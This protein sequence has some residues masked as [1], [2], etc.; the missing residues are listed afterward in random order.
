[1]IRRHFIKT[2]LA[3]GV[4]TGVHPS[5]SSGATSA[6]KKPNAK[7]RAGVIGLGWM[8]LLYDLA[9]RIPDRFN[10][11][12][13]NRPTP[14]LDI[15]RRIYHHQHPGT[16]G[17]PSSYSEA[18]W[19]RP[20]VDLIAG[21]D[22]DQKRLKAFGDR[23]GLTALYTDAL[24][25]MRKEKLDIVAVCTNVKGRSFLTVKAAEMGA[26]AIFTE[27]PM[28]HT[29]KEADEMVKACADRKIP[30]CCG[31][32][33]TTHPS[34]AKAK[35]LVKSGAIGDMVSIEA[36]AP[37]AQHQNW[38]YFLDSQP[39]WV[40]GIGDQPR[41]ET[42]SDEFAGQ[43]IMATQAGQMV[44]F[45][46]GAPGVRINGSKGEISFDYTRGWTAWQLWQDVQ[47]PP[48]K[49]RVE[50]PWPS[51]QFQ[52]PYGAVYCLD[53]LISCLDGK[54]DEPKNSGRRVAMAFE[55]EV[56]LKQSSKQGGA[57]IELP[58]ADRSLGLNY[59]WY[60]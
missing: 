13:P 41:R 37:G 49:K 16:E 18:L 34:F 45:R 29:L 17:L 40:V 38:A 23:Y 59:D 36:G 20:E 56:A 10:V 54:L 39:A 44:H 52:F 47:T 32:I 5:S 46:K 60:R 58:L 26:K 55:V 11:D 3:A 57:R 28:I 35:E 42:G 19:D 50:M 15:Q 25:M 12:D 30:L 24:E 43:G 21:A 22:R 33:S 7:Y 9:D 14:E 27:K 2:A 48:G 31:A 8:G 51:P 4:V 1:M 6:A 53:D